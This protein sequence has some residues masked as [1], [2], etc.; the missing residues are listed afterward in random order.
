MTRY[1][2]DLL[3]DDQL[4]SDVDG[5]DAS[6]LDAATAHGRCVA[7]EILQGAELRKRHWRLRIYDRHE[8]CAAVAELLFA[9]NDPALE[10]LT[11]QWRKTIEEVCRRHAQLV[12]MG[13]DLKMT[14]RETRALLAR[15][16]GKPF[17]AMTDGRLLASVATQPRSRVPA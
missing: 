1:Y 3:A 17:L 13:A 15:H 11:P 14:I 7:R 9:S 4:I 8:R 16:E 6:D 5:T 12:E 10:L 2:F